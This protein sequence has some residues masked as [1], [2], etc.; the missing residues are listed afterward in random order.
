MVLAAILV[1][2]ILIF[3]WAIWRTRRTP[4]ILHALLA[5][6]GLLFDSVVLLLYY[7]IGKP[8]IYLSIGRQH[9]IY[10]CVCA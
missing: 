2:M 5:S 3:G 6:L 7:V 8:S 1:A 4:A 10:M 9:Y